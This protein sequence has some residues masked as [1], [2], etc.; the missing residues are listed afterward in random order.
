MYVQG[1]DSGQVSLRGSRQLQ[2]LPEVTQQAKAMD[3]IIS[4]LL[5][6]FAALPA[7][8]TIQFTKS[9]DKKSYSV[10]FMGTSG[11]D[12]S[13]LQKQGWNGQF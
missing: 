1:S 3:K 6:T 4:Q 5:P 8:I 10:D 12:S 13:L 2:P 11:P 7:I 9:T